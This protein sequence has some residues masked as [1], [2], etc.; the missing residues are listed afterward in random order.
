MEIAHETIYDHGT[1]DLTFSLKKQRYLVEENGEKVPIGLPERLGVVP[2]DFEQVEKFA[3][4]LLPVFE[5]I[6]IPEAVA[7][8]QEKILRSERGDGN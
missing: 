8:Y 6:W 7:A 5:A 1:A 3:P 4:E 2:G